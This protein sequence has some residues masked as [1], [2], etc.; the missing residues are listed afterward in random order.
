M[1]INNKKLYQVVTISKGLTLV[2]R[3]NVNEDLMG[4]RPHGPNNYTCAL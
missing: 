4:L 1:Y 2:K 3:G